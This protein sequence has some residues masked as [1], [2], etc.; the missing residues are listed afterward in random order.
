M[1]S[2]TIPEQLLFFVHIFSEVVYIALF[3][4]GRDET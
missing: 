3:D 1:R 4:Y 2:L